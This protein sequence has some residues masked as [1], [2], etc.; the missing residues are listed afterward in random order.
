LRVSIHVNPIGPFKARRITV[1][2]KEN[3]ERLKRI[4]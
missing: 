4:L 1:K 2:R 3:P